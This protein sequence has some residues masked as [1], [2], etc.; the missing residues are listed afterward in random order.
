MWQHRNWCRCERRCG[1][2]SA[3]G[4]LM[5]CIAAGTGRYSPCGRSQG[6][7]RYAPGQ[8]AQPRLDRNRVAKRVRQ[9]R[10]RSALAARQKST[11]Q[12]WEIRFIE[13][14]HLLTT[15]ERTGFR[16]HGIATCSFVS[17]GCFYHWRHSWLWC[18]SVYL[19]QASGQSPPP[20]P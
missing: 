10:K 3:S 19:R 12:A 7:D 6:S 14:C 4:R 15:F 13:P 9:P 2:W 5:S 17:G 18:R 20:T 8:R 16:G 11:S 1:C